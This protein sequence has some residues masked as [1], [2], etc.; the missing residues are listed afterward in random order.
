MSSRY[1]I[2]I[3]IVIVICTLGAEGEEPMLTFTACPPGEWQCTRTGACIEERYVCD[4]VYHCVDR[5]DEDDSECKV[6][7]DADN[8]KQNELKFLMYIIIPIAVTMFSI[9]LIV[10]KLSSIL[11]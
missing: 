10:N 2:I 1:C 3:F 8:P 5:S 6:C 11:A 9:E 4:N 7:Y